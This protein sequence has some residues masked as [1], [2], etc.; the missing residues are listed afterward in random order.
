MAGRVLVKYSSKVVTITDSNSHKQQS[1]NPSQIST[2]KNEVLTGSH[3]LRLSINPFC[4][5]GAGSFDLTLVSE[6]RIKILKRRE[7]SKWW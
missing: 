4:L 7:T 6:T 1:S 3:V 5:R 2:Q